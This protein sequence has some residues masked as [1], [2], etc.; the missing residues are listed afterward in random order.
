M[1]NKISFSINLSE[2]AIHVKNDLSLIIDN[3]FT[4]YS[5]EPSIK[6]LCSSLLCTLRAEW[7][8]STLRFVFITVRK[9]KQFIPRMNVQSDGSI[10]IYL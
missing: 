3:L 8:H 7:L 10:N 9:R 6:A 1:H 4:T 5:R 2:S